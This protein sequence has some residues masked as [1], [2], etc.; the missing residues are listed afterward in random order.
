MT[1]ILENLNPYWPNEYDGVPV[2]KTFLDRWRSQQH[3]GAAAPWAKVSI[4]RGYMKHS[5]HS[6]WPGPNAPLTVRGRKPLPFGRLVGTSNFP[7]W[8]PDWTPTTDWMELPGVAQIELNQSVNYAGGDGGDGSG[9]AGGSNGIAVATI[10][11]DNVAWTEIAGNLGAYHEK[12]RGWLWPWRGWVPTNRPGGQ[13]LVK[14]QWYRTLP[15]AQILVQQG[16]GEDVAVKTFTG[17]IDG[18]GPGTIRPDRIT[19]TARDFGSTLVDV[20]PFGWN[21]DTRVKDPTYFIPPD[22]PNEAA[23]SKR[24]THNWVIVKD[25]TDIV[26]CALRWCG[27][28]EWEIED[29][30]VELKTAYL[31]DRSKTWM[32]VINEV[33]SQLGYVFFISE[34][35]NDDLSI[36]VPIFRKQSVL[37]TQG[38]QPILLDDTSM[39]DFQPQHDNTNDRF[40]I[41][42]RGALA[43]RV[44]GGRPI[45]GGDMTIDGQIRVTAT[46]F[47]PW[48]EAM[49]GIIKQLTYYNIGS[50]GVLGFKTEQECIVA[51]ILIAVQIALSRDTAQVECA[52]LP[53]FGLDCMAFIND[54][55][56]SGI[57]SRLYIT[58]KQST[59][60]IGG[61]GSSTSPPSNAPGSVNDSPFW[62]STITGSLIDNPE[63]DRI[64][65]DYVLATHGKKAQAPLGGPT[66]NFS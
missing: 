64:L 6:S 10:T 16:Y 51:T 46:Y 28:K 40:V 13:A 39:T 21:K 5:M 37:N 29:S 44:K 49:S 66:S 25:A 36:G 11:A 18:L 12:Q 33:A 43:S 26:R 61:D 56:A 45:I 19:L 14:N 24:K 9:G 32:D 59:M 2:S 17:L 42:V 57:V 4:R 50:N 3:V 65:Q 41:R 30:G 60:V 20:N 58:G 55:I 8:Y 47:P 62:T 34:P 38:R 22:Y 1:L 48:A 23:L 7:Q 27:F 63:W 15:N 52:G 53:A 54:W 31:V 35:T